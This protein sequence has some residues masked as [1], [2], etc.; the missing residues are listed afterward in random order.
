[1]VL[2]PVTRRRR[3]LAPRMRAIVFAA[4]GA[5]AAL[6]EPQ[7]S[8]TCYYCGGKSEVQPGDAGG[9]GKTFGDRCGPATAKC[10]ATAGVKVS[11]VCYSSVDAIC[12]CYE[13]TVAAASPPPPPPSE[14]FSRAPAEPPVVD[15]NVFDQE[16]GRCL[17]DALQHALLREVGRAV[18]VPHLPRTNEAGTHTHAREG[19]SWC[20]RSS[21]RRSL[22]HLKAHSFELEVDRVRLVTARGLTVAAAPQGANAGGVGSAGEGTE[23]A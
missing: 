21:K 22:R 7:A 16:K 10:S 1:M 11:H 19:E 12:E 17:L 18:V 20:N 15:P 3:K 8:C 9:S 14:N 23:I 5:A 2:L 6:G 4:L 13:H